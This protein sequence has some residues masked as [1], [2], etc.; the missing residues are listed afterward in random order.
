M[1]SIL[2]SLKSCVILAISIIWEEFVWSYVMLAHHH[3]KCWSK[4]DGRIIHDLLTSKCGIKTLIFSQM[5]FS[6]KSGSNVSSCFIIHRRHISVKFGDMLNII[7][8]ILS[9]NRCNCI[10]KR[11]CVQVCKQ[12]AWNVAIK[13][14]SLRYKRKTRFKPRWDLSWLVFRGFCSTSTKM[15]V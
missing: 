15:S 2:K 12:L 8:V 4:M 1:C 6:S 3:F 10:Y 11:K 7:S 13:C 5:L 14:I 9:C